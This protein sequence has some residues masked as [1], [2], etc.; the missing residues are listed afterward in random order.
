MNRLLG[1][2]AAVI[3]NPQGA[4]CWVNG[5]EVLHIFSHNQYP[6]LV[7]PQESRCEIWCVRTAGGTIELHFVQAKWI[8]AK[9]ER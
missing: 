4:P 3:T 8:V 1:K 2:P 6:I 7:Q 5:W 9:W